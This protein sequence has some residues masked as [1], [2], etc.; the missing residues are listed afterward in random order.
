[1]AGRFEGKVALVTG[2]GSG[3][4]LASSLAFARE[5]ARV[6]ASDVLRDEGEA[7]ARRIAEA[8]GQAR[9]VPADV[10]RAAEVESLVRRAVEAFGRL[11]FAFNNAG[12]EGPGVPTHEHSEDDWDRVLAANLKGVWLCMSAEIP[13]ML[14]RG[15]GAIVNAASALGLVAVPNAAAYC[16]AKHAVVGLTRAAALDYARSNLRVNAVCPG[17]IRTPMIDRV[18]ARDPE[19]EAR[20]HLAEP[21]GRLGTPEE[22]AEA[23]LWLC[24][25]AASFVTG[26]ALAID[27]G[28]VAR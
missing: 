6:V 22:V 15:G 24:S 14:A 20:M 5:G 19:A 21:V 23:V 9:F 13:V 18:I 11:D 28:L 27:G 10:T 7:A 26:H 25:D 2:A 4:G 1:M 12:M 3:I 8:G 17:Y 16:A